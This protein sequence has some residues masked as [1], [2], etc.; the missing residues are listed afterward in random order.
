MVGARL[1]TQREELVDISRESVAFGFWSGTGLL[2]GTL[3]VRM[4]II[5]FIRECI[6]CRTKQ[7]SIW[8]NSANWQTQSMKRFS[9]PLQQITPTSLHNLPMYN[10]GVFV[11]RNLLLT[12]AKV[13][14][15]VNCAVSR[16]VRSLWWEGV[17]GFIRME[18]RRNRKRSK[19]IRGE[20]T[21]R[22]LYQAYTT[23]PKLWVIKKKFGQPPDLRCNA[24]L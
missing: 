19:E 4:C 24:A 18:I 14:L 9:T 20:M 11:L 22:P 5:S 3:Q 10:E 15:C 13:V 12:M 17:L 16:F 8:S 21:R 1:L 7:T 23:W 2:E 6:C